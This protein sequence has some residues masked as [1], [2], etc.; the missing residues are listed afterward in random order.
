VPVPVSGL[1]ADSVAHALHS[2]LDGLSLRQRVAADNIA[3]LD[4]PGYRART[5]DF[6]SSLRAAIGDGSL[7]V[8]ARPMATEGLATTPVG[9]SGNNV[10]LQSETMTAMRSA[11][12]YQLLTRAVNDK[13][14]LVRTALGGM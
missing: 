1:A 2:A 13:F 3:N 4:T 5:V 11:F 7:T 14:S 8:G 10:D 12:Q 6:E 9:P